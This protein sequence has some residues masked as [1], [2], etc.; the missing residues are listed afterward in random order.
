MD[1]PEELGLE[2][3]ISLSEHSNQAVKYF[4]GKAVYKTDFDL[5]PAQLAEQTELTLGLGKV[6][7]MAEVV[8]NGQSLGSVWK[9]PFTIAMAGA[10]KAGNNKLEIR[11]TTTWHNRLVGDVKYPAGFPG[12]PLDPKRFKTWCSKN[13]ERIKA[14]TPLQ[15]TG[16]I[17][18]VRV[19]SAVRARLGG[20]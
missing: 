5:S 2:K 11:V 13:S 16:L 10:A 18:P 4:S 20:Q 12:V 8:L 14:N 19:I 15:P 17:G 7:M 1:V 9:P 3:L 6:G